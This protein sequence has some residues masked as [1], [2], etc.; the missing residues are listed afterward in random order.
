[1]GLQILEFA[2]PYGYVTH[3][4]ITPSNYRKERLLTKDFREKVFFV[5]CL[6][7]L[8]TAGFHNAIM[9]DSFYKIFVIE[10]PFWSTENYSSCSLSKYKTDKAGMYQ[11][12]LE[13]GRLE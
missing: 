7:E 8:I 13:I 4:G 3:S 2:V 5:V 6:I 12:K 10:Q 1:L 11:T 9:K